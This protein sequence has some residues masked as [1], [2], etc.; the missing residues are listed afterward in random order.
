[1]A[2]NSA[3]LKSCEDFRGMKTHDRHIVVVQYRLVIK[4]YAEGVAGVVDN[5]HAVSGGYFLDTFHI[6]WVTVYMHRQ[7]GRSFRCNGRFDFVGIQ[8]ECIR[9]YINENRFNIIG[10]CT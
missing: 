8:G 3:P 10:L 2:Y 6:T 9:F 5:S 7:D 4:R 1:M